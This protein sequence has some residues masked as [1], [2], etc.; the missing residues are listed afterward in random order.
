ML[1]APLSIILPCWV[2][3]SYYWLH[4]V[5]N[6]SRAKFVA[7]TLVER[8]KPDLITDH[9]RVCQM[10][11]SALPLVIIPDLYVFILLSYQQTR[12]M[13]LSC[14]GDVVFVILYCLGVAQPTGGRY[15]N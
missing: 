8:R 12:I 15:R 3:H 10:A 9:N 2:E 11:S 7:L 4:A 6:N 5:F 1:G 13:L 14:G